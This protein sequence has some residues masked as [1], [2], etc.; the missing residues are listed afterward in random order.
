MYTWGYLVE[1]CLSKLDLDEREARTQN[2]L[3][4]F[5]YYANEVI[6]Q[7]SSSIKPKTEFAHF[8]IDKTNV[9]VPQLMPSDFVSFGDDV[10]YERV[11]STVYPR[12]AELD[13]TSIEV[14]VEEVEL[15][16]TDFKYYGY[17]KI[18]FKH[19]GDFYISYNARWFTFFKGIEENTE[20]D[21]PADI[22]DCIPSYVASQCYKV[23]DE[24]KAQIY[25]NEYEMMLA[26][27][28][29][30]N[31]KNTKTIKIEGDW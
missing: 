7:I 1:V 27:I 15:H 28:D 25:R 24:T 10:N 13:E 17:N 8:V 9:G 12:T 23:D 21:I 26:R 20:L 6:T 18:V 30:T 2:L 31:Y 14:D 4:R 5:P 3:D 16:D 22:L 29:A 11:I 19:V